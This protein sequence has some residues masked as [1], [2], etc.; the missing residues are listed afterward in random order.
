MQSQDAREET[1]QVKS[2]IKGVS[3]MKQTTLAFT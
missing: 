3:E 1:S 2:P